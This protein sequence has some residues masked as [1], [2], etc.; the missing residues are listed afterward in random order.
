MPEKKHRNPFEDHINSESFD[1][2]NLGSAQERSA[3]EKEIAGFFDSLP[4]EM[5]HELWDNELDDRQKTISAHLITTLAERILREQHGDLVEELSDA[6]LISMM[7]VPVTLAMLAQQQ[8]HQVKQKKQEAVPQPVM[9]SYRED[10]S[11][12]P[13]NFADKLN[14]LFLKAKDYIISFFRRN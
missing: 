10:F 5:N 8:L 3:I 9:T 1:I 14:D 6:Q 7:T 4:G 2:S 11:E 13:D 12:L